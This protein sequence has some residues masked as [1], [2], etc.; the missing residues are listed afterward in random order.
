MAR[1][2][3]LAALAIVAALAAAGVA[4]FLLIGRY[5]LGP[6]VAGRASAAF[7][8]NVTIEGLHVTP[9]KWIKVDL[10]GLKVANIDSGS[11]P[12]MLE[13]RHLTVEVEAITLLHG[14]A[15][16]RRST[17]DGLSLLLERTADRT[18]N[19]KFTPG[20]PRQAKPEDRS[21]FPTLLDAR[22]Q[23]SEIIYRTGSGGELRTALDDVTIQ[24][25]GA[26]QPVRMAISG[27]YQGTPVTLTG[28][29][30]PITV[31]RDASVPFGTNL[32]LASGETMLDFIGTMEKPLDF[33]GIRGRLTLKA[34]TPGPILAMAGVT[35]NFDASLDLAGDFQ[36]L[37]D[38]WKLNEATGS[39]NANPISTASLRFTEGSNG[40]PDDVEVDL[41]FD[42][43]DLDGLLGS[44]GAGK[45]DADIGFDFLRAPDTLIAASLAADQ[46]TYS[47]LRFTET[48]LAAALTPGRVSVTRLA[49][50]YLGAKIDA[51]G[52]IDAQGDSGRVSADL[53]VSNVDIQQL[54][55]A[56]GFGPLPLSG[57]L[58]AKVVA[59]STGATLN[60]ATR[61]AR[62]AAAISMTRGAISREV[63]EMASLD[64]RR[65][66]RKP[67]GVSPVSCMLGVLEMRAG[68]GTVFPLRI[69]SAHGTIA[70]N[71]QFNL[72]QRT[73][74]L[75]IGSQSSTTSSYALDV[76]VR[77]FGSFAS[78]TVRPATWSAA[79][80]AALAEANQATRLPPD[81]RQ[82]GRSSPCLSPR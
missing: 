52:Q 78:P 72:Y 5:D 12:T 28:D 65:L 69:R 43:L 71:A 34:P 53:T 64:V 41:A 9:G 11:R 4:A 54:R 27:S 44:G 31:L 80:R 56:L 46:L 30:Q 51:S 3:A 77:A 15:V 55:K 16:V 62:V 42:R 1:R 7:G 70:G 38:L 40:K 21:W 33:D 35:G 10:T 48:R 13:L 82:F 29:L 25:A 49:L 6:L 50:T 81:L 47:G 63:I 20:Q 18:A 32:H 76:P 74:D 26:D 8:R 57:T 2:I 36:H 23:G 14:P 37:G 79:G 22:M 24:T 67:N 58:N 60:A 66:F 39:L 73:F 61:T 59:N 17:I 68:V 19:W 45:S 75:T